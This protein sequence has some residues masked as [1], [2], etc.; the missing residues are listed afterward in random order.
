MTVDPFKEQQIRYVDFGQL[1]HYLDYLSP[2]RAERLKKNSVD[3]AAAGKIPNFTSYV[4]P[5]RISENKDGFLMLAEVY[6]PISTMSP[7]YS[8]PYYYNPYYSPY[9]LRSLFLRILLPGYEQDVQT[10]YLWE[11]CEK[12]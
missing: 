11:Q 9:G 2:A 10:I 7:Y 5:F 1:R 3:D 12:C 8:N 4:M 6:N